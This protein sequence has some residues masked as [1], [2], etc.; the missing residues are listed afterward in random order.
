MKWR[1]G[2]DLGTNSTGWAAFKLMKAPEDNSRSICSNL[3]DLGVR[4]FH[5][6]RKPSSNGRVGECLAVQRRIARGMRRNRDRTLNRYQKLMRLLIESG[7]MPKESTERLLLKEL[8]PYQMRALAVEKEILPF[9]LG[10]ALL[11]LGKRRGFKANRKINTDEKEAGKIKEG[12]GELQS[13]LQGTTLGQFLRARYQEG[14]L[15]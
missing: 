11:H 6:S 9:E 2:L 12:I 15:L 7:L 1:L 10:R 13:A 8:N 5:E 4:I 3:L 14:P